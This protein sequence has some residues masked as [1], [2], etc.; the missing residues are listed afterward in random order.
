MSSPIRRDE[1]Q[2]TSTLTTRDPFRSMTEWMRRDPFRLMRDVFRW[3]PYSDIESMSTLQG[4]SFVPDISMKETP[5]AILL[6][7]DVPG[8]SENEIDISVSG[9]RLSI[10]GKREQEARQEGEQYLSY[11]RSYGSFHRSFV[12]PDNCD[13]D[14]V[15]A[16]LKHGVLHVKVPKK[17]GKQARRIRVA[18]EGEKKLETS[19]PT[20]QQTASESQRPSRAA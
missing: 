20:G 17:E 18:G 15:S 3:D 6:E 4:P 10:S 14:K 2:S 7:A 13:L 9:N 12:F 16:E 11:E 1:P 5:D 19:L 8:V